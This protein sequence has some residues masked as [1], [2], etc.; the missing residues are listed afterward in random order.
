MTLGDISSFG[1]GGD[2][3][4]VLALAEGCASPARDLRIAAGFAAQSV[5]ADPGWSRV[6]KEALHFRSSATPVEPV[7]MPIAAVTLLHDADKV[8]RAVAAALPPV[9]A[10]SD[11]FF[12]GLLSAR[13]A[14][15]GRR[16]IAGGGRRRGGG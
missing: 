14:R 15:S 4:F 5:A 12:D 8:V 2:Y 11:A 10:D 13:I 7:R 1:G 16:A 9:D 6:S 3:R